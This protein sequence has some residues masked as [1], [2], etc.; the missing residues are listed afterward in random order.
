MRDVISDSFL[1]TPKFKTLLQDHF[2][3]VDK[4]QW[5]KYAASTSTAPMVARIPAP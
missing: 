3:K 4:G 1:F 5:H 2:A